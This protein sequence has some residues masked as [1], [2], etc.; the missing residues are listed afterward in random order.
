MRVKN[1]CLMNKPMVN[2]VQTVLNQKLL[3]IDN[4]SLNLSGCSSASYVP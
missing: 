2:I 4:Q 3:A 1:A